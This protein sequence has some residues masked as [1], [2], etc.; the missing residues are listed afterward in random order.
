MQANGTGSVIKFDRHRQVGLKSLFL[1][2]VTPWKKEGRIRS[3]MHS[4]KVKL[5][6][7]YHQFSL[8]KE[9]RNK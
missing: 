4:L 5:K 9:T 2:C 8:F 1:Y 3:E 6:Q 7:I